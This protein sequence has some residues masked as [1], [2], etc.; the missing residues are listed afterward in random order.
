MSSRHT[1]KRKDSIEFQ[2]YARKAYNYT[3][4]FF[5]VV[6][7]YL[8]GVIAEIFRPMIEGGRFIKSRI[9]RDNI[10]AVA[11]CVLAIATL[12][13]FVMA[14]LHWIVFNKQL[15]VMDSQYGEMQTSSELTR[16]LTAATN[17]YADSMSTMV[18]LSVD[19]K[20][21]VIN[22]IADASTFI[23]SKNGSASFVAKFILTNDGQSDTN[24]SVFAT[25]YLDQPRRDVAIEQKK[26]CAEAGRR[27]W[28]D[29]NSGGGTA[30]F[31]VPLTLSSDDILKGLHR[32]S[33]TIKLLDLV[34]LPIAK[35]FIVPII[36]GCINYR[37]KKEYRKEFIGTLSELDDKG[38]PVAINPYGDDILAKDLKII[39]TTTYG[40]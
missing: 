4:K 9:N 15:V 14:Y 10:N 39:L 26:T 23:F 31:D 28:K 5:V 19:S 16:S 17:R 34:P 35:S 1:K 33:E 7:K 13:L 12:L 25:M 30:S 18:Q 32:S 20:R 2:G 8:K 6:F 27:L 3:K 29:I 38:S 36:A 21:P 37:S 24:A 22:A 11:T 40:N